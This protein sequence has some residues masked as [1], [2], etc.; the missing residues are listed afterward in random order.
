MT[1]LREWILSLGVT[2]LA[3]ESRGMFRK[4]VFDILEGYGLA[5][6]VAGTYLTFRAT[7]S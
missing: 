7:R 3:M 1:E 5:I 4:P 6:L 2:H